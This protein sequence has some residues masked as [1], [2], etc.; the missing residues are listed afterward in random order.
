M[1]F[2]KASLI[3]AAFIVL[4][5]TATFLDAQRPISG[6]L[7]FENG[8]V[9]CEQQCIVSLVAFGGRP[10]ETVLADLGAHFGFSSVPRGGSYSI[11]V[12]I[13]GYEPVMQPIQEYESG[14]GMNVLVHLVRKQSQSVSSAA[15]DVVDVSE[16]LKRY[17]KKAVSLFEKGSEALKKNKNND[18]VEY[19]EKAVQL[20]PAFYEAHNQLGVAYRQAGRFEDAEREFLKAHELNAA[21]V[22]PLVNLTTLYLEENDSVSAVR[23]GEQAVRANSRSAPAF[24]TLGVALYKA[25]QLDRAEAAL[26]RALDLAP[27]MANVRLMLANV[28]MKLRRYDNTL[29][30]LNAYITENPNGQQ[31]K[32]AMQMRTQLLE[33]KAVQQ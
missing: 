25:A 24:F 8:E 6:R 15:G 9:V 4:I 22:Q 1:R 21:G 10:V 26:K 32:D 18:A 16:F 11:R 29:E 7:I 12:E 19:L 3:A 23:V 20:A 30:Q 14:L 2:H 5:S 27:K 31:L 17:P 28:Y 33:A 13:E